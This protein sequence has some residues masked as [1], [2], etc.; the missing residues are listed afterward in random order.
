MVLQWTLE[1]LATTW[2]VS[3]DTRCVLQLQAGLAGLGTAAAPRTNCEYLKRQPPAGWLD[4]TIAVQLKDL[5][6]S[7]SRL[8][9]R[10][11]SLHRQ[12]NP[13]GFPFS[14]AALRSQATSFLTHTQ[15]VCV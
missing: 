10:L 12:A 11:P 2:L 5:Y 7:A 14:Q 13:E 4:F 1:G 8:L 6:A 9:C 15:V 3:Q